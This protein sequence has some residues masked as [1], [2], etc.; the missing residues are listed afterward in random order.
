MANLSKSK[1]E[2]SKL[3]E[4]EVNFATLCKRSANLSKLLEIIVKLLIK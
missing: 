4:I 2:F 3:Q 1:A